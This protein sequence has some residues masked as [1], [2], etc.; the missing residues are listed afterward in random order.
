MCIYIYT[1]VNDAVKKKFRDEMIG[2]QVLFTKTL[3][4]LAAQVAALEQYVDL[5]D[6]DN[7]AIKVKEVEAKIQVAQAKARLFNAREG[8]HLIL[9]LSF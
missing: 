1:Q 7:I 6:V 4:N 9:R 2:D 3:K 5:A 8:K